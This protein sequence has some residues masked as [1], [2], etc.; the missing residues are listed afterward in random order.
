MISLMTQIHPTKDEEAYLRIGYS[1]FLDLYDEIMVESFWHRKPTTRLYIIKDIF[2]IYNELIQYEPLRFAL[3]SNPR[4]NYL[5]VG[6]EL[7]KFVRNLLL[8]F[9]FFTKWS[10][11]VFSKSLILTFDN[12]NSSIHKFLS[13]SYSDK[14]KYRFWEESIKQMTYVTIS[15]SGE[16]QSGKEVFLKDIVSEKDGVKFC[17]VFMHSVL[18]SQVESVRHGN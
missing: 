13:K 6:K 8:H 5:T 2:S 1:R 11:I 18:M 12:T 10:E 15:L 7:M 4:P 3:V 9:P 17:V 16:Y 14:I